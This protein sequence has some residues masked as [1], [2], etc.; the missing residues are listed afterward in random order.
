[1]LS[2]SRAAFHA[3]HTRIPASVIRRGL[4]SRVGV[5]EELDGRGFI[6]QVTRSTELQLSLQKDKQVIYSGIDPTGLSLHVGHLVPMMCLLHFHLR[7]HRIIPLIG[8]ATALIGDP[9]GRSTER[10][11]LS[12]LDLQRNIDKLRASVERFFSRA[13][14]YA[15]T[16]STDQRSLSEINVMN[17]IEWFEGLG[18]L[19]FLRTAG[20]YAR[21]NSM[22]ARDSV[23]ARLNSQ[24]GISFAEFS[25]QLLQA[26]DFLTL[27]QKMGCTIQVG[28][29]DQW[30]NI[31][32]GIELINRTMSGLAENDTSGPEKGFG[33]TTPLLTTSSGEKFGKSAG[34]AVWLDESMTSVFDF[35]QFFVRTAD[36]DVLR[37]L[38]LFTLLP[39]SEIEAIMEKH[40]RAPELRHAQK[41]LADEVTELV[42][43]G[44]G[45]THAQAA[46]KIFFNTDLSDVNASNVISALS[47]DPRL[48]LVQASDIFAIPLHKVTA[49]V[50]L[51][52]SNGAAK[53][54][55]SMGG[56]YINGKPA[57][58]EQQ[59]APADLIDGR[60]IVLRAGKANHV[61]LAISPGQS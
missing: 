54:L 22:I 55:I 48:R 2:I 50:G 60:L 38:K 5:L 40:N 8:G 44:D 17:N 9:S 56:L 25:Y 37:Y 43:T 29:S 13:A 21:V 7:G 53:K 46:T 59:L 49:S 45:V 39:L 16:K 3:R 36:E 34:N 24:Q 47:S 4:Q 14:L 33:I 31:I 41:V 10:P 35:Y 52:A 19:Q 30:G 28:G 20:I 1:M 51:A 61:V 42:H 26:Y 27:N 32:S 58:A 15:E 23:Q 57:N 6:S 18:L 12:R 11:L